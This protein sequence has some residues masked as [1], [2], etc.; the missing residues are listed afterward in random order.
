MRSYS[1]FYPL[2]LNVLTWLLTLGFFLQSCLPDQDSNTSTQESQKLSKIELSIDDQGNVNHQEDYIA[3]L[4]DTMVSSDKEAMIDFLRSN[5]NED[6]LSPKVLL[7][8]EP[9]TPYSVVKKAIWSCVSANLQSVVFVGSEQ[10]VYLPPRVIACGPALEFP[11]LNI[12]IEI[13]SDGQV[14]ADGL[15]LGD[16]LESDQ[17]RTYLFRQGQVRMS[18]PNALTFVVLK[19]EDSAP[20][21]Y[22]L[23]ILNTL[24]VVNKK[25]DALQ[26]NIPKEE[27]KLLDQVYIHSSPFHIAEEEE[28][29]VKKRLLQEGEVYLSEPK[30]IIEDVIRV[31]PENEE[32]P[33]GDSQ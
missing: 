3:N 14:I 19:P 21:K 5:F 31:N 12:E 8:V 28:L 25:L 24:L 7:N 33:F 15:P 1:R 10:T 2:K 11:P 9:T 26:G 4:T 16:V 23:K 6:I 22:T 20:H 17:L 32:L 18:N 29:E 27:R 30:I 13:S